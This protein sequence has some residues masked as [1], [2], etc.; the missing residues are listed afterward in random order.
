M[1]VKGQDRS[2][3]VLILIIIEIT[4]LSMGDSASEMVKS[5]YKPILS[6]PKLFPQQCFLFLNVSRRLT[7]NEMIKCEAKELINESFNQI[8]NT[9]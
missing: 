6:K 5:R 4:R 2:T 9:N 8:S 3:T 7:S 1:E